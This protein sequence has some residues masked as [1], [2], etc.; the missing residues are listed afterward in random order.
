M[1]AGSRYAP[2]MI[3]LVI[4]DDHAIVRRGLHA[5]L[6]QAGGYAILAECEDACS[7]REAV[8]RLQPDLLVLDIAMP[9]GHGLHLAAELRQYQPGLLILLYSQYASPIYVAEARRLGLAGFVSKQTVAD[10]LVD[11]LAAVARGEFY[12]S[13]DLRGQPGVPGF[14]ALTDKEREVF[15]L[16]AQGRLPKQVGPEMGI[17]EKTVYTHRDHIR[18]KLGLANDQ[19][20]Q[21]LAQ[22]LGL[23]R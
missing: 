11:A 4:A 8:L 12:L 5:L 7:T 14:D 23:L 1:P 22:R 13:Q 20:F 3:R 18:E 9:G 16:L 2:G 17:S 6:E 10:E 21:Q 15:L 19:Q